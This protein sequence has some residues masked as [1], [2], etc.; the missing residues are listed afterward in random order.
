MKELELLQ[1]KLEQLIKRFAA[2]QAQK[3]LIGA[4]RSA[5]GRDNYRIA[6]KD[7]CTGIGA[8]TEVSGPFDVGNAFRKKKKS[9]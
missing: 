3:E 5:A 2:L 9:S 8:A 1:Q 6:T 7:R 4:G